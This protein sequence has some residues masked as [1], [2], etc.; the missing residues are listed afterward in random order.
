MIEILFVLDNILDNYPMV[1]KFI[2][3]F[4]RKLNG[5][6]QEDKLYIPNGY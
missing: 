4:Y 6:K 2:G 1:R 5:W 3:F